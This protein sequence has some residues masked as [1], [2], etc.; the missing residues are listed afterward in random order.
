M[1]AI[2]IIHNGYSFMNNGEMFANCTC[3]LIKG[4]HN[5]IIDT[6]T[7]WDSEVILRGLRK[8]NIH[9]DQIDYVV[10][11]H[12]HSDHIGNNNLFLKA[13]HIVGF[14]ISHKD[15]FYIHPFENGEEYIINDYVKVI[16]TPGHT[17][18][19]VT[20]LVTSE[21]RKVHAIA[22]ICCCLIVHQD[23]SENP[24]LQRKNRLMIANMANWIIPGHGPMFKV[25]P[26]I[27]ESLNRQASIDINK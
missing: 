4:T 23:G 19:D 9:P 14:S 7:A 13:T 27:R 18:S 20:V 15:K 6:M 10:S 16:P 25:T 26:E 11:T 12:G 8:E 2:T 5:I 22:G 1:C 24:V 3:T 21:D 17:L